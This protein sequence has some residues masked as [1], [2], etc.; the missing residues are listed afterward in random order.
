MS[1][2]HF[3]S[4]QLGRAVNRIVQTCAILIEN[5]QEDTMKKK[6]IVVSALAL[7]SVFANAQV[8]MTLRSGNARPKAQPPQP[9]YCAPCLFYS[10]DWDPN[11]ANPNAV[12]NA[13]EADAGI[14]G[15][16]FVPIAVGVETET[17]KGKTK[18][19]RTATVTE[20]VFNEGASGVSDFSGSTYTIL[21]DVANNYGGTLVKS[22]TCAASTAV[23]TGRMVGSDTEYSFTCTLEAGVALRP[24]TEYWVNVLPT[25]TN[26]DIAYLSDSEDQPPL[27][28][29]NSGTGGY[30]AN[31]DDASYFT[32]SYYGNYFVPTTELGYE[33]LDEFSIAVVG[34]Y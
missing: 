15:Q 10:G 34:T 16:V 19:L 8:I 28:A 2:R 4:L 32:S 13:N 33:G 5:F 29:F 7:I 12:F 20:I 9:S 31:V 14:V 21:T 6:L 26:G 30:W 1:E 27:N 17:V 23:P 24:G 25:F 18:V 11:N 3:A 22:G